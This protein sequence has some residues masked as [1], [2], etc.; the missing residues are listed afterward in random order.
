MKRFHFFRIL[1]MV[2]LPVVLF[3]SFFAIPQSLF[4]GPVDSG[5]NMVIRLPNP[6]ASVDG[7]PVDNL[8]SFLKLLFNTVI[9]PIGGLICALAIMYAGFLFVTA[10]G[11]PKQLETAKKALLYAVIGTGI[12]LGA[13]ALASGIDCT[14]KKIRGLECTPL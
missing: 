2:L 13:W 7:K 8:F 1:M 5:S 4:A 3:A 12:L 10:Q 11:D 9:I 14:I 6:L